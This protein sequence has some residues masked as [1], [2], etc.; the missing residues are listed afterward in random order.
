M[1]QDGTFPSN[2]K[3]MKELDIYNDRFIAFWAVRKTDIERPREIPSPRQ[4]LQ[5]SERHISQQKV[6]SPSAATDASSD[7]ISFRVLNDRTALSNNNPHSFGH[8]HLPKSSYLAQDENVPPDNLLVPSVAK[9]TKFIPY[10]APPPPLF[11]QQSPGP[12]MYEDF[13]SSTKFVQAQ[14]DQVQNAPFS[15]ILSR[16]PCALFWKVGS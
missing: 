16:L 11:P 3:T 15:K 2:D 6:V 1:R 13:R 8:P 7:Q 12:S 5:P 14:A 4:L 9:A 10:H